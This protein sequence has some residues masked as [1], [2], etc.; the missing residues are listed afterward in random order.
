MHHP[1][2][3]GWRGGY[4]QGSVG[5]CAGSKPCKCRYPKEVCNS[6]APPNPKPIPRVP[7][8]T[9]PPRPQRPAARV[10][11]PQDLDPLAGPLWGKS[12]EG[13]G[14]HLLGKIETTPCGYEGRGTTYFWA[15][16]LYWGGSSF[17]SC[18]PPS[19]LLAQRGMGQLVIFRHLVSLPMSRLKYRS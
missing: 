17:D 16:P 10:P 11:P 14:R 6:P 3:R 9:R 8:Q 19:K 15:S 13:L 12:C 18:E 5:H 1:K 7:L 2:W 4:L